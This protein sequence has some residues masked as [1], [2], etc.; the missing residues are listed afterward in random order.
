M[1]AVSHALNTNNSP[2]TTLRRRFNGWDI[3][4]LFHLV[5]GQMIGAGYGTESV[6][7]DDCRN[8]FQ[9]TSFN[10]NDQRPRDV[11]AS[12]K[13]PTKLHV[14]S[15]KSTNARLLQ[16]HLPLTDFVKVHNLTL[17]KYEAGHVSRRRRRELGLL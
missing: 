11:E 10:R 6:R 7:H 15:A 16:V 9:V 17:H 4:R 5:S 3:H 2:K 13:I 12:N 14:Q 8:I 1:N